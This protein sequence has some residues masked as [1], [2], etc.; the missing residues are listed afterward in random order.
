VHTIDWSCFASNSLKSADS[1]NTKGLGM[2][3]I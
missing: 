1:V 3:L 2:L